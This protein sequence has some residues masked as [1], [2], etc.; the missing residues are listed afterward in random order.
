MIL[1][2]LTQVFWEEGFTL[3]CSKPEVEQW[4]VASWL[5]SNGSNEFSNM[6]L[7][8]GFSSIF[9]QKVRPQRVLTGSGTGSCRFQTVG[10]AVD[11]GS[12]RINQHPQIS[13]AVLTYWRLMLCC[14]NIL[15]IDA[16]L[17]NA[18]C[19]YGFLHNAIRPI[20][21]LG[22]WMIN[23]LPLGKQPG[24]ATDRAVSETFPLMLSRITIFSTSEYFLWKSRIRIF[25]LTLRTFYQSRFQVRLQFS[26]SP[27]FP[28]SSKSSFWPQKKLLLFDDRGIFNLKSSYYFDYWVRQEL[29]LLKMGWWRATFSIFTLVHPN[30]WNSWS[31]L[32]Y[33]MQL[34]WSLWSFCPGKGW[35]YLYTS[36]M[37][38]LGGEWWERKVRKTY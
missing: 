10:T 33:S 28:L 16:P 20:E 1:S 15:K 9:I 21:D 22:S 14:A 31:L 7:N 29:F 2:G 32:Q 34:F 38:C 8:G 24:P 36:C 25:S 11:C 12:Y 3:I 13:T 5:N 19:V 35:W 37:P 17:I 18:M 4:A 6:F 30:N 23:Q 27:L 26:P